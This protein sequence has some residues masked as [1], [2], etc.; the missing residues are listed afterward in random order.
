MISGTSLVVQWLKIHLPV[1]GLGTKIPHSMGQL[2]P[3]AATTEAT[4][5]GAGASQITCMPQ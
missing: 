2:S 4:R 5:S 1:Q 3:K